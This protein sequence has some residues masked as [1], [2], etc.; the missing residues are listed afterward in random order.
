M[1]WI[2]GNTKKNNR[3]EKWGSSGVGG[4]P[5]HR[6]YCQIR[7]IADG[8]MAEDPLECRYLT[9]HSHAV[10]LRSFRITF[11]ASVTEK[12]SPRWLRP[13]SPGCPKKSIF[14]RNLAQRKLRGWEGQ[15]VGIVQDWSWSL[16]VALEA[17]R[18]VF[19]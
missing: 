10:S 12:K 14:Q 18:H 4:G 9:R 15:R 11:T 13:D 1:S 2:L 8:G 7:T 5:R 16:K 19:K 3:N 6:R 17:R